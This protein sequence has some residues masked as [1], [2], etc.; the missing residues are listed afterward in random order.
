MPLMILR[1]VGEG[2]AVLLNFSMSH[3]DPDARDKVM[4]LITSLGSVE[5][6]IRLKGEDGKPVRGVEVVRWRT[7]ETIIAALFMERGEPLKVNVKLGQPR[8]IYDLR[9]RA[10]L[11]ETDK[12]TVR[13]K[14]GRVYLLALLLKPV[15]DLKL[16]VPEEVKRGEVTR[17]KVGLPGST[18]LHALKLKAYTPDGAEVDW[19]EEIALVGSQFKEISLPIAF[20]DPAG[21][22][23]VE[24]MEL[25]S[26][27]G[28]SVE[29]KVR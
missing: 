7:G 11:G 18:G 6:K 10:A 22:W 15:P 23:R 9:K 2:H 8:H 16:I 27:K 4:K 28:A 1:R 12:L 29:M 19:F 26:G 21:R 14:P 13:L 3:L 5:P 24:A 20:N 17:V 25:F